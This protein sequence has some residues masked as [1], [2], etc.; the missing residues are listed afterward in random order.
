MALYLIQNGAVGT[1]AAPTAKATGTAI[2]T[3]LQFKPSATVIARVVEWGISFDG[4]AAA[5]PGVVEL[6]E[7]NVAATMTTAHTAADITKYD[8]DAIA[9]GDPT[10]NLIQVGTTSTAFGNGAVTEG[11]TTTSRMFD[12]QFIAPTTQYVKQFPLGREPVL[13]VG[14]FA[15][16]RVTFGTSVNAYCYM[17]V[18]I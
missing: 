13:Q 1:T 3:L 4:S 9:G 7:S 14:A 12:L 5:T 18:H 15:R 10:T 11:S 16:I 6:M 8:A 17:V 2:R